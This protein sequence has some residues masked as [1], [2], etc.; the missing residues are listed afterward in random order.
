M[1]RRADSASGIFDGN[2][3][4]VMQQLDV[5]VLCHSQQQGAMFGREE[6]GTPLPDN[7][8]HDLSLLQNQ[9]FVGGKALRGFRPI[10]IGEDNGTR[11]GVR[12]LRRRKTDNDGKAFAV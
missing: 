3:C 11:D 1:V 10:V 9:G 7:M 6:K 5:T 4:A 12:T 2:R 8:F